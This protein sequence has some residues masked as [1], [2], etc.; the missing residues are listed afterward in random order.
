MCDYQSGTIE[1]GLPCHGCCLKRDDVRVGTRQTLGRKNSALARDA[2]YLE[3]VVAIPNHQN[4]NYCDAVKQLD[5]CSMLKGSGYPILQIKYLNPAAPLPPHL[6]QLSHTSGL[7]SCVRSC[8][9]H[10]ID[11]FEVR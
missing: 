5:V 1:W 8:A 10:K 11:H 9:T 3:V 4:E 6:R 2:L 7:M